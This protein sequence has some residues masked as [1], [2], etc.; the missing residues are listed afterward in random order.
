MNE[1]TKTQELILNPEV[2]RERDLAV[3]EQEFKMVQRKAN[4]LAASDLTPKQFKNNMANCMIALELAERLQSGVLEIMQNI[5]IVHG[6]PSF[7]STYL[8]ALVNRS[9]SIKGRLRF[10]F[11]GEAG[12]D[13]YGCTAYAIDAETDEELVGTKITIGMARKEGWLSK[14]GSKWQSMPDQMLMYRAAA[15]W[16]RVYSPDATMG[17]HT[18]DELESIPEKEINPQS[19]ETQKK[20]DDVQ[21]Q[22]EGA[23]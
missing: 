7:S 16:S 11:T 1:E 10:K 3:S 4:A 20:I 8:I 9:P 17:F 14:Q 19:A 6:N 2:Q 18:Y 13:D 23:K 15:F 12:T 5:Y 22:L 21:K